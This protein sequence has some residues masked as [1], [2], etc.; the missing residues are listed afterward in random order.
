MPS[1][2][3]SMSQP[4]FYQP[5]AL[6]L[7]MACHALYAGDEIAIESTLG[8][9]A[10]LTH[11]MLVIGDHVVYLCETKEL[12]YVVFR[13]TATLGGWISDAD[14]KLV[15]FQGSPEMGKVH[16]GFAGVL[17][18]MSCWL[19]ARVP[20]AMPVVL[21]GHSLGGALATLAAVYLQGHG[22]EIHE[23]YTFGQP[24]V[25]DAD[26][27]SAFAGTEIPLIR[28]VHDDDPV[29]HLPPAL[30]GYQHCGLEKWIAPDGTVSDE[31]SWG[32]TFKNWIEHARHGMGHMFADAILDH[33]LESYI[34]GLEKQLVAASAAAAAEG[35]AA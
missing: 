15:P 9:D 22:C 10:A 2:V 35:M 20:V 31:P 16:A 18:L 27:A 19:L 7:A 6:H 33:V 28:M 1:G 30:M 13:G 21:T 23:V 14:A 11:E 29:P 12:S 8:I 24:R 3:A 25:G 34:V 5:R 4:A 17:K 26:F 32:K